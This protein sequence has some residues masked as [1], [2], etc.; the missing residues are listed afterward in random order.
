MR[1]SL[2]LLIVSILTSFISEAQIGPVDTTFYDNGNFKSIKYKSDQRSGNATIRYFKNS[3]N[4][5]DK[6]LPI[7][8][9]IFNNNY[10]NKKNWTHYVGETRIFLHNRSNVWVVKNT[11]Y[12]A[13]NDSVF[14]TINGGYHFL[15]KDLHDLEIWIGYTKDT[16]V[17]LFE[18]YIY[19]SSRYG[20][21]SKERFYFSRFQDGAKFEQGEGSHIY[22]C[23]Q[24]GTLELEFSANNLLQKIYFYPKNK[25]KYATYYEL[26]DNF[27]CSKHGFLQGRLP[28]GEW[29][30]Y[31]TNGNIK[32]VG[33]YEVFEKDGVRDYRKTGNWKY[34]KEDGSFPSL[35]QV[36]K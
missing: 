16:L 1:Q 19:D 5:L 7:L 34:F 20:Y 25:D 6:N 33:N 27:F 36:E 11:K 4:E 31:H 29:Y 9:T 32:S 24:Y 15:F 26:Y 28:V 35:P 23:G 22:E 12:G 17:S 10:A 8:D 18:T 30:E 3:F 21:A 13:N 2:V 14:S